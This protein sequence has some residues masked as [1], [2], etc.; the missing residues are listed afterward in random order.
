MK[1]IVIVFA[2][3]L[4]ACTVG[5]NYRRPSVQIPDHFRSPEPL[6]PSAVGNP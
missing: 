6:G 4:G 2:L 3:F 1:N 5:P